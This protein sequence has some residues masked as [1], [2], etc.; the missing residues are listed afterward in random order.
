MCAIF[1]SIEAVLYVADMESYER[2]YLNNFGAS[3]FGHDWGGK[4]CYELLQAG[5]KKPCSFCTNDRIVRE[6]LA[7]PPIA[8][9]FQNTRTGQWFQCIDRALN[10]TDAA[11]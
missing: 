2:L 4:K 3:L 5:K 7:Q 11:R 10:W 9:E 8:W 6:G 1:D